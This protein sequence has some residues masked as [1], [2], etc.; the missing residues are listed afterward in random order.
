MSVDTW[1]PPITRTY[2]EYKLHPEQVE[3]AL[4]L[5]ELRPVR[6]RAAQVYR[7]LVE[8]ASKWTRV[9][10]KQ[11][12][13]ADRLG[14]TRKTISRAVKELKDAGLLLV[15]RGARRCPAYWVVP[16]AVFPSKADPGKRWLEPMS[17]LSSNRPAALTTWDSSGAS[18]LQNPGADGAGRKTPT[19]KKPN[20]IKRA[21]Q[22]A[23]EKVMEFT[24]RPLPPRS[25][26]TPRRY[27][28]ELQGPQD[29]VSEEFFGERYE[30]P[31]QEPS[32]PKPE[33]PVENWRPDDLVRHW[34]KVVSE[35]WAAKK[36]RNT[37]LGALGG[38]F[39][40]SLEKD[41]SPRMLRDCIDTFLAEES[42]YKH[43]RIPWRLFLAVLPTLLDDA[44]KRELRSGYGESDDI[45]YRW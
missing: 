13:L 21:V 8:R 14:V 20:R 9:Y 34:V 10:P 31:T 26:K 15:I 33:K 38:I 40:E 1:L 36:V 43:A 30:S 35:S 11:Q 41:Y 27:E 25:R 18:L 42:E 23:T 6:E 19:T 3:V 12:T 17:H 4:E 44:E 24:P 39:K 7:L 29:L 5:L 22:R 2:P 16:G 32:E 28:D 37:N 45:D